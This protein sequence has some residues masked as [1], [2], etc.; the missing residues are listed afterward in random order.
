MPEAEGIHILVPF[1]QAAVL[2]RVYRVIDHPLHDRGEVGIIRHAYRIT[3]IERTH[4][5]ATHGLAAAATIEG[6]AAGNPEIGGD[7]ALVQSN[8]RLQGFE[9]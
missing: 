8:Q 6:A 7:H 9:R 3:Q 1:R 5:Q 2:A 4:I